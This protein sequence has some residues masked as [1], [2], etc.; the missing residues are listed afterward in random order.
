MDGTK[1]DSS[2]DKGEAFGFR[3]G[4]GKVI[5]GWESIAAGMQPYPP[6]LQPYP[7]NLQPCASQACL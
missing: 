1:F 2:Y 5:R 7:P 6:S 3:L 4:K